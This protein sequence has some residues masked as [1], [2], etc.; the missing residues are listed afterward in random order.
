MDFINNSILLAGVEIGTH[1]YWEIAGFSLHGQ[2]FIVSWA[3]LMLQHMNEVL[4][5]AKLPPV[6]VTW[7]AG[8]KVMYTSRSQNMDYPATVI[9]S[10]SDGSVTIQMVGSKE[11]KIV[12][13]ENV[14]LI[15]AILPGAHHDGS[16]EIMY[17]SRSSNEDLPGK[18]ICYNADGSITIQLRGS[19]ETKIIAP[20]DVFRIKQFSTA[21]KASFQSG[22]RISYESNSAG[23]MNGSVAFH[24][25]NGDIEIHID[26][27]SAAKLVPACETWR[28]TALQVAAQTSF[29]KDERIYYESRSAGKCSGTV[30]KCDSNGIE[31]LLDGASEIKLVPASEIWRVEAKEVT[32]NLRFM[33]RASTRRDPSGAIDA[34]SPQG[35]LA[36]ALDGCFGQCT[37]GVRETVRR[38]LSRSG[39]RLRQSSS[40]T[41]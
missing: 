40:A 29:H 30:Q 14:N 12:A 21:A 17:T 25:P 9:C 35:Y 33:V 16:E 5:L 22:E 27:A 6:K 2:V 15:K 34:G 8:D 37:Q 28:I 3:G 38:T 32:R 19:S 4:I 20:A 24:Y 10:N 26:G 18:I 1:Y 41:G 13:P 7:I 31:L 39:S 36:G 23:I 11:T